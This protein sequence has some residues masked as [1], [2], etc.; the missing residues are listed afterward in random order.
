[1]NVLAAVYPRH[2]I[3]LPP[4][5]PLLSAD[6]VISLIKSIGATAAVLPPSTLDEIGKQPHLL[7]TLGNLN[8]V[9]YGG[10]T[11]TKAAGDAIMKKTKL[12]NIIGSTECG[13][14]S[15]MEVEQEDWAYVHFSPSAGIAFRHYSGDEFEMII[16]RDE[17]LKCYQAC[18][19]IFPD[20]QE[21][22][23]SD[24][25]SKHPNKPD[26]WLYRGRSDDVIVFLNGEKTNPV[27]MEG[28]ISSRPE[29]RN[30]LVIGQGRLEAALLV[31]PTQ[32]SGLSIDERAILIES[33]WPTIQEANKACPAHARVSK[34]HI[35][36][37]TPQK[38]MS[39]AGKG[40][41][42]RKFTLQNYSAELDALYSDASSMRHRETPIKL[43]V[44]NL[45]QSMLQVL[46]L[47]TGIT[48][49]R[50]GD[51]FFSHGMDSLQVIQTA[52]RLWTGLEEAGIQAD[53]LAPS[54]I[55]TNPTAIQLAAAVK[56][57]TQESRMSEEANEQARI[58]KMESVLKRYSATL[59]PQERQSERRNKSPEVVM[60]TGS[61][62]ALGSYLLDALA[63]CKSISKIY[64]LN[65]SAEGRKRQ[66]QSSG[67][68]GLTSQWDDQRVTFL[69]SDFSKQDLGLGR[70]VYSKLASNVH[71]IIHN[72]W[73]VD[74][75]LSLE[76]Y[77]QVHIRGVRNLIDLSIESTHQAGI[78]FVSS[79]SSVMNWPSRHKGQ[80]PEEVIHD[81]T[82][83]ST[84]GYAESKHV[85]ERL[86]DLAATVSNVS[87][88]ICRVGQ[89]A[90]PVRSSKGMW[91]KQEWLPSLI[92]SSHHLEIIPDSLGS[93][94]DIDWIP[95]DVLS[96][97][98]TELALG[99]FATYESRSTT[100]H[101]VNSNTTTWT[102]LLPHIQAALGPE[103]KVVPF[104]VWL[105]QLRASTGASTSKQDLAVNP[106]IKLLDFYE[107]LLSTGTATAVLDTTETQKAN[108]RLIELGPVRGEWMARWIG[109]WKEDV[110]FA[111]F[112][113]KEEMGFELG[114]L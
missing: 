99:H 40:T 53:N 79:I 32:S 91:N 86:L 16:V 28:L 92:L 59:T 25:F 48:D 74:F 13:A 89:I 23:S 65:R 11:I 66:E 94:Q 10:G 37:T 71:L 34:S 58:E 73:Q 19:E 41:V 43:D 21:I 12:L 83:P 63:A 69:G 104:Q 22:A 98:I 51:D 20:L 72:A 75:N 3:V 29:V 49:L 2:R 96:S 45:E 6:G 17:R 27:S 36:F 31:E 88:S 93:Q 8:H 114:R 57:L 100:Y 68:R 106:A 5:G 1:M 18:F 56:S 103:I 87:V 107:S 82:V 15:H 9:M 35:L 62:G 64:C 101:T 14:L 26:L 7:K 33:L 95:I 85:S 108:T 111:D 38:P 80:V 4:P 76:S 44:D 112:G 24:L 47:T 84:I 105:Q 55:Y 109:Q 39:R 90:G 60:L 102:A 52:R 81:S 78:F 54:T 61:T 77:E 97:I 42:Q 67:W 30:A 70:S 113:Y 110:Q 46:I 50:V